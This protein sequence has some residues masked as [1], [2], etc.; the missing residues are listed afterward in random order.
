MD[1]DNSG[2]ISLT[3]MQARRDPAKMMSKL[4]ADKNGTLSLEE[5]SNARDH[6]KH[7]NGRKAD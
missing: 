7:G 6:G 3:E 4:D 2:D 1:A 5:F